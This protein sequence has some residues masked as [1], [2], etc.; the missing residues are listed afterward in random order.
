MSDKLPACRC[1]GYARKSSGP[2]PRQVGS[3]SD[4]KYSNLRE[5]PFVCDSDLGKSSPH[6]WRSFMQNGTGDMKVLGNFRRLI[7]QVSA[8]QGYNPSNAS[9]A[10]AA[11]ETQYVAALAAVEDVAAKIAPNKVATG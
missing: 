11:L 1:L 8:D 7:D 5:V 2:R 9:L 3:L 4:K 6:K 10:K